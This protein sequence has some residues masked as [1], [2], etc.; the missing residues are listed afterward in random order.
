ML[1]TVLSVVKP[2][3]ADILTRISTD[4]SGAEGSGSSYQA[5]FSPDGRFVL[6]ASDS[7]LVASDHNGESDI[8]LKDLTTGAVTL[9]S[10]VGVTGGN[11]GSLNAR[12]SAG[13]GFVVFESDATNLVDHDN[14]GHRDIFVKNLAT[15][16]VTRASITAGNVEANGSSSNAQISPDG[17]YVVFESD[18]S[19]LAAG[20]DP[21]NGE[22]DIFLKDME[23]GIIT[24]LS[25]APNGNHG[26]FGS[27][28]ARFSPD[29]NSVVFT[30][31]ATNLVTGDTNHA[32]DV[33]RVNLDTKAIERLSESRAH[34]EANGS[35]SNA[36]ISPDGRYVVFESY[37]S[38]LID[39]Q[40]DD[41]GRLD[42]F[43]KDLETGEV[44][45]L[46]TKPDGTKADG[47]SYSAHFSPDGRYVV[48]ESDAPDLVTG[49]DN[50]KFD[51]FLKNLDT[52]EITRLS[53][54][55]NGME[56]DFDSFNAQISPDG[57]FVTFE[58]EATNLVAGDTNGTTDIFLVN[59]LY[60]ANAAAIAGGRFLETT[61]GVGNASSLSIDWGDGT[62]STQTPV[63]G[64]VSLAHAY[65]STGAKD[66]VVTLVEGA[67]SWNVAHH[68]DVA[69]G[70]MVRNTAVFD[71]LSGGAG[72]DVLTGDAFGN[73]LNGGGG[74]DTVIA[75]SSF[76]LAALAEVENL[77]AS[78]SAGVSLT[79][80]GLANMLTGN[81]G[82]NRLDG[83]A[84][85]DVL[86]GGA[87]D[88][89]YVTDGLD[90]I[91]EA[92]GGG[93]DTVITG[94]SFSLAAFAE[95]ENLS[96]A[97]GTAGLALTGNALA[98]MLT[99]NAGANR[100][101]GGAGADVLTGGLGQDSL[102]GG[103]GKDVFAFDDRDTG[104]AK[105]RADVVTDFS[106][107]QGDRLDLRAVDANT[108]RAGDQAFSFI[109]TKAF[110]KAGQVRTE[111]VKGATY[112]LLNTDNDK[113][114]EAVIKLK[115]ALDLH[116]GWFVL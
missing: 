74:T 34:V 92:A 35:S 111:T 109:G 3:S 10:A 22:A 45:Y 71:T 13:G 64:Q 54:A 59:L 31:D 100:L 28:N 14:E 16:A 94:S 104:A 101:S 19:N 41:D 37:A 110:S 79:G 2:T 52:K 51:I 62:T 55:A 95:V 99:G 98:N 57:R 68:V 114:A 107:R 105:S 11:A 27:Y 18:A 17:R 85:A 69:A 9:L 32:Q 116:K 26:D 5:R 108:K 58:S 91:H 61:L 21:D 53:V 80:N 67:L 96:A 88:D 43:L 20:N 15:G 60:K 40:D 30:S 46:A 29:G 50:G 44:T 1:L 49:D 90:T 8:F 75:G 86:S 25:K 63:A 106:G 73:I 42:I 72:H 93:T 39:G 24:Y 7:A 87:G 56:S 83:G 84:G 77:T 89:T 36:Q 33:F 76:S 23:T 102:T 12:F 97:E 48:F 115:G 6:F 103:A 70:A 65:A 113:A 47:N 81:A 82:A 66:A 38:N 78:G 112:V 4:S